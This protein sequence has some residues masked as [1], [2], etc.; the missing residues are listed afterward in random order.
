MLFSYRGGVPSVLPQELISIPLEQLK[1][2][3]YSG[4]FPFPVFNARTQQAKWLNDHWEIV[5]LSAGEIEENENIRLLT[6]ANWKLFSDQLMISTAYSKARLAAAENLSVNVDCT[7]LI[8]LLGDA[9]NNLPNINFLNACLAAIENK[10]AL[11]EEDK[12]EIYNITIDTGLSKFIVVPN[13]TPIE[14][15]INLQ[16]VV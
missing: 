10:I 6:R 1:Q 2:N 3:G 12:E 5:D 9:K 11:T 4:P 15:N 7:E 8:A 16:G 14:K 13:Y